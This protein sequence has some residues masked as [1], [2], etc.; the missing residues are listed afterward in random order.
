MNLITLNTWGGRAGKTNLLSFFERYRETAIFCLQEIWAAPYEHLNGH[1][2]GGLAIDHSNI[3]VHGRQKIADILDNHT[4]YFRPHFMD[5][6]GLLSL[7]RKDIPL[8]TEGDVFVHK[9]KGFMPAGDIGMHARNMQFVTIETPHG[10]RSILNFH[11]LWNGQGKGDSAERL[12][13]SDRIIAFLKTLNHPYVLAGDFNLT[14]ATESI[15]KL[16]RSG[17]RNLITEYGIAS[18]RTSF[19]TKPEKF[20]DYVFVSEGITINDFRVLPDEVSDHNALYLDFT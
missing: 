18:T 5:N 7:V 4:S 15:K 13:Q 2:A 12:T 1:A 14:P 9:E 10:Q 6:Y 11:G 17:M 8:V 3:L 16:E 19:Y 20:A